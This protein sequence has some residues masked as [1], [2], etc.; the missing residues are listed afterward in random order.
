MEETE[1]E[2][3]E[4]CFDDNDASIDPD[5]ALSYIDQRLQNVLGH[6]QKDFEG[7]MSA[8]ILGPKFGG[9][10]SFLPSQKQVPIVHSHIKNPQKVQNSN[11]WCLENAPLNPPSRKD[12]SSLCVSKKET[13]LSKH[14]TTTSNSA[15]PS[16]QRSLKVRIKVGSDKS[17]R[18]NAAIYSG[19]GLSSP[20]SS[21]GND[22]EENDDLATEFHG[23]INIPLDSPG[24]ILRDMTS[25]IVPGNRLLSPLHESLLCLPKMERKEVSSQEKSEIVGMKVERVI[26]SRDFEAKKD[27]KTESFDSK[28]CLANDLKVNLP[29][30]SSLCKENRAAKKDVPLKKRETNKEWM[31][32]HGSYEQKDVKHIS[33]EEVKTKIKTKTKSKTKKISLD[34]NGSDRIKGKT[35]H[36]VCKSDP[37]V[38]KREAKV[39]KKVGL[40]SMTLEPHEV[41]VPN[42]VIT[43]LP[44]ERNSKL[45]G[46]QSGLMK[47]KKSAQKDIVKVRNSYKDILDTR[48]NDENT[49]RRELKIPTGN[50]PNHSVND[51]SMNGLPADVAVPLVAP[52]APPDNWVGCDRCEKWRLLP[53]GMEPEN[54]PDKWL[55]SMSTWLPG[56]NNCDISEDETTRAVQEMNLQLMSQNQNILQY[57]NGSGPISGIPSDSIRHSDITNLNVD[58]DSMQNRLKKSNSRP[59]STSHLSQ[60]RKSLSETN[61]PIVEKNMVNKSNDIHV[62][63]HAAK[64]NGNDVNESDLK[65]KKLKSKTGSDPK[66]NSIDRKL[67]KHREKGSSGKNFEFAATSSS[68]KVSDSCRRVN[69][70]ERKGSPVGSVSSSPIKSLN[71]DNNLS[72][73]VRTISRKSSKGTQIPRKLV[74]REDNI[75]GI[76]VI[77]ASQKFGGKVDLKHKEASKIMEDNA[78]GK[79]SLPKS[80]EKDK[81]CSFQRVKV[82]GSNPLTELTEQ[83]SFPNKMRKVEVDVDRCRPSMNP[84]YS[85]DSSHKVSND[86]KGIFG[87]KISK[88]RT[89]DIVGDEK[90]KLGELGSLEVKL[91]VKKDS[92]K[93]FLGDVSKKRDSNDIE[94][95][96]EGGNLNISCGTMKDLG[97]ISFVKEYA[98]SQTSMTAFKRA[99]ESKDYADRIKISGFDYECNDAY[100]DSALK[101]LYAAFLL[102]ASSIDFNKPKGVDPINVYSTSAKLS[103]N[104]AQEYEKQKEMAAATLAYKCMEVAYMRIVYCKSSFTKQDLQTSLQLVNQGESPSSSASDVDNLN[105]Q[106]TIDKTVLCKSVVHPG[107]ILVARNQANFLRLLDFTSD[108]NLA[109]EASTNTQNSY[110]SATSI[111]QE[112][113]N[114]DIITSIKRVIEFSFQDVKEIIFLVQNAREAINRRTGSNLA[115]KL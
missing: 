13:F 40:K 14:E 5:V 72:P 32:E 11:K 28:Q 22:L 66:E 27:I 10:G 31:K 98:S 3:G 68:S 6:F 92:K 97:V 16:E 83:E 61:Q 62:G 44:L 48:V 47:D 102:E 67:D 55:C 39:E 77:D 7:G 84:E 70:E 15:N 108:V 45:T 19:L 56:R 79:E 78:N 60:K 34:S 12:T 114:K 103:K 75:K 107:N 65:P 25:F 91:N 29:S 59:E 74:A 112:S 80:R 58:S 113:S 35:V 95:K 76:S 88:R 54:L 101:F 37:D 49:H 18:K 94:Q 51:I 99:E 82:K 110:K 17:T 2:E 4:A 21:M 87:K 64:V 53:A 23:V 111:Q 1:L 73:S 106:A 46:I 9:Y 26:E 36:A 69:L 105:N 41:K 71:L 33:S 90:L 52:V 86:D 30:D 8:E 24:T 50:G 85:N 96:V 20:S 81:K 93:V 38:C 115:A 43:K 109:M 42:G 63:R 104:C 89:S 57:N 100:F